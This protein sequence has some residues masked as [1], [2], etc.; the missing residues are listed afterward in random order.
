MLSYSSFQ[1]PD[2]AEINRVT[3]GEREHDGSSQAL[4]SP[5]KPGHRS[6]SEG[7]SLWLISGQCVLSLRQVQGSLG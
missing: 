3:D 2:I 6:I 1:A 5:E 7:V 4:D